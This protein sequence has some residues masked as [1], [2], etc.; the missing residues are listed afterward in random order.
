MRHFKIL[1]TAL[2]A[3]L[4]VAGC[5]GGGDGDQAPKIKFT[6]MV[7]FGDSLSDIGTYRVGP[8]AALGGGRFSINPA[9]PKTATNW[10][11]LIAAQVG[12]PAPCAARTGGFGVSESTPNSALGCR[13]YAQGGARVTDPKGNGNPVGVGFTAGPLTEPIVTQIANYAI[14]NGSTNFSGKELVTMLAG[15]NDVLLLLDGL[16]TAATAAGQLAFGNS[17]VGQL[18]AGATDPAAAALAIGQALLTESARTGHTDQSVVAEAVIAAATQAGNSAVG[19]L[20]VYGPMVVAAQ[21]AGTTAGTAY[22]TAN[23][24]ALV[25]QM[26]TAGTTLA[27][28]IKDYIVGKGA[29]YVAVVNL[30]DVSLTPAGRANSA[31]TQGLINVMVTTFNG[32]LQLGLSGTGVI[33]VDAYSD[34]RN[35]AVNPAS[36]A[37]TNVTDMACNLTKPS[38]NAL[39]S[40]LV[41]NAGNLNTGDVSHYLF[42]DSVHPTPYGYKLLAQLTAKSLVLAGWL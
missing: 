24:P 5:G 21:T 9:D 19:S 6:S 16:S 28:Y 26:A 39:G 11:E 20:A 33:I 3:A 15:G 4:L 31:Q 41:C 30:P 36:Y 22:A 13:N 35:Q 7:S 40:S 2:G 29:K 27:G 23:G 14:D 8:V 32:A 38:P 25:P 34:N 1:A 17:L 10:T 37:L 42:A 18:A 12:L